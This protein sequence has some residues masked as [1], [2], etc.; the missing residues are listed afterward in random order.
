MVKK[1]TSIDAQ[2]AAA[3]LRLADKGWDKVTLDAVAKAAKIKPAEFKKRFASSA[4][5]A[6][7]I[8][9]EID[10]EA[11]TG[12]KPDGKPHDVLFDLLMARFDVMQK[13]RKAVLYMA[14]AARTDRA[15]SCALAA[16]TLDGVYR[17]IES[18]KLTKPT[19]PVLALGL[20]GV[21]GWGFFNWQ[22]DNSKDMAK[23][24]AA[25]DRALRLTDKAAE[26]FKPY[27]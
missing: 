8:A 16:A 13:H 27:F 15:L 22:R 2:I 5:L 17:I 20:A 3:T 25:L 9:D 18:A 23:T 10:R 26:I 6:P 19:R 4:K 11:F 1:H 21:Y 14:E 12:F 24:M 7:V